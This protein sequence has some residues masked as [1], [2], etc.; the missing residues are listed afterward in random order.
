[1]TSQEIAEMVGSRHDSV[2]RTIE[3]LAK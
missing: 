3:R 1:M 2:K